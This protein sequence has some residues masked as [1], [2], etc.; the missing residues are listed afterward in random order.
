MKYAGV[1]RAS[2]NE[3]ARQQTF[4]VLEQTLDYIVHTVPWKHPSYSYSF[5]YLS[6]AHKRNN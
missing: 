1:K 6:V 5:H 3:L 2:A 4:S